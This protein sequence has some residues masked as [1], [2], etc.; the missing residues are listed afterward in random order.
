MTTRRVVG[1]LVSLAVLVAA[2]GGY[3]VWYHGHHGQIADPKTVPLP[4]SQASPAV[5][6]AYF[7]QHGTALRTLLRDTTNLPPDATAG[8]CNATAAILSPLGS[9]RALVDAAI[10]I[11]DPGLRDAATNHVQAVITYLGRC[12]T[13]ADLSGAAKQVSFTATVFARLLQ[14]DGLQ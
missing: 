8:S 1:V 5:V 7:A 3:A 10:G 12:G 9:P 14:R 4:S 13:S 11:P 6:S 2:G